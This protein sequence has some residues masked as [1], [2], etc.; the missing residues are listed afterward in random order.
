MSNHMLL[1][2]KNILKGLRM[3]RK[4]D[5]TISKVKCVNLSSSFNGYI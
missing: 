2:F 5:T 4:I 3:I 1:L